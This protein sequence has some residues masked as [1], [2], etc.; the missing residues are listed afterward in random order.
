M[1]EKLIFT[2]EEKTQIFTLLK[3]LCSL[4]GSSLHEGDEEKIR[5]IEGVMEIER[6]TG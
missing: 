4:L 2:D 3:E 6:S 1:D 5:Q